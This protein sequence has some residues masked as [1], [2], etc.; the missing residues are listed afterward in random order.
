MMTG[1]F[2]FFS[3]SYN[4]ENYLFRAQIQAGEKLYM[5]MFSI[6]LRQ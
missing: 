4:K 2:H 1:A 5:H 3:S 6:L